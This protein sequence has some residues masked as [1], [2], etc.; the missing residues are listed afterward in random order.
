M[1]R[2]GNLTKLVLRVLFSLCPLW[3][4]LIPTSGH[5]Q[6]L[7]PV[8]VYVPK[9][10]LTCIDWAEHLRQNGFKV[11]LDDTQDMVQIKRRYR[12]SPDLEARF[13][14][15]VGNYFVEG[16]VPAEDIKMLL[17]EQPVARGIAVPGAPRGAPG[18][19]TMV[20]T[21]C[22]SGCAILSDDGPPGGTV[23]RELF[24][25]LLIQKDGSTQIFAR[26]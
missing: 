8:T 15:I 12:I 18:L 22:E 3:I 13:T 2:I 5:A 7:P 21:G 25:T 6:E 26:H 24:N 11:T 23:R 17:T 14:A 4:V 20:G 16:H 10:C 9:V 1:L 19:D